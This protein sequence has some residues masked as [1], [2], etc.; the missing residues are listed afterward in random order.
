MIDYRE[1][2]EGERPTG[3]GPVGTCVLLPGSAKISDSVARRVPQ[4]GRHS[5]LSSKPCHRPWCPKRAV[6]GAGWQTK[7]SK[8][9]SQDSFSVHQLEQKT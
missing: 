1:P 4:G 2:E 7:D 5:A 3:P 6:E 8:A 9:W